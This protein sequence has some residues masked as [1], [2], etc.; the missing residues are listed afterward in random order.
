[1]NR[2]YFFIVP[3]RNRSMRDCNNRHKAIGLVLRA[4][5]G[6]NIVIESFLCNGKRIIISD[7]TNL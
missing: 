4:G 1:M 2:L 3:Y 5:E 7:N 6:C